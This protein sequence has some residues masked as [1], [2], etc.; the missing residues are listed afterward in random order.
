MRRHQHGITLIGFLVVLTVLGF[1]AFMGM[2]L[3]P[4]YSEWYSVV[5]SMKGLATEPGI[6][7]MGPD[8]IR[9]LFDRRLYMSYVSSV[10]PNNVRITTQNG[11]QIRV[12]YE[13]RKPFIGNLDFVAT[14]DRTEPLTGR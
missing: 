11:P 6:S 3:F 12:R 14:F 9:S 2:R 5:S 4:V 7:S 1:F 10:K 8:Q 13:V